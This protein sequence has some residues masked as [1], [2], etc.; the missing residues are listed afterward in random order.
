M[1]G[2]AKAVADE[3]HC[4]TGAGSAGPQ[5][6]WVLNVPRPDF[7]HSELVDHPVANYR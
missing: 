6:N 5:D 4:A 7:L 2:E 1:V 3:S